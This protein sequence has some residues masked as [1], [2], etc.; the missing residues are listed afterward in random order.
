[1]SRLV[2]PIQLNRDARINGCFD[3]RM[4]RAILSITLLATVFPAIVSYS[5]TRSADDF[6][7]GLSKAELV[8]DFGETATIQT[9]VKQSDAVFG[10][11]PDG[12][13]Y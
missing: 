13:V 7:A 9:L 1:M 12:V 10:F 5:T 11:A 3:F 2:V 4:T 6:P 8:R